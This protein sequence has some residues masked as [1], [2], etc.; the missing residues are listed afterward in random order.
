MDFGCKGNFL[1]CA[2]QK[3]FHHEQ[4]NWKSGQPESESTDGDCVFVN[5]SSKSV[6]ESTF[7]LS[8]CTE[9]KNFGCEVRFRF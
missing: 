8:N 3:A 4:V 1:W 6:N 9:K 2:E 7:A 5:Y